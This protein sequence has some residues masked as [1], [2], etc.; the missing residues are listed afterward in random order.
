MEN[1]TQNTFPIILHGFFDGCC[2]PKNPGGN[3]GMGAIVTDPCGE[4]YFEHSEMIPAAEENSNNVAEYLAFTAL[5][6]FLI[7][8][9]KDN[10]LKAA[11]VCI[12]GDSN[13]VIQQM[14]G[15]WKIKAGRYTEVAMYCK[16]KV[17]ELAGLCES[18]ELK[19]ISRNENTATDYLSKKH[20]RTGG[21]V[22]KMQREG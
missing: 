12:K 15:N 17:V 3:M 9:I 10:E 6:D 1:N 16:E 18:L 11:S 22:F 21:V 5:I 7:K 4:I 19:W 20:L 2:E 8:H 14:R 13:L